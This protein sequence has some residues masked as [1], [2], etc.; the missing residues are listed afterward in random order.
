MTSIFVRSLVGLVSILALASCGGG[1]DIAGDTSDFGVSPEEVKFT[2]NETRTTN[3]D[4]CIGVRGARTVFTIVGGQA[5][6]RIVNSSPQYMDVDK[7]EVSG[8]DPK[9]TVTMN[10]GC[11]DPLTILVLDYHSRSATVEITVEREKEEEAATP[12]L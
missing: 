12:A 11:G 8:K 1:G 3:V 9:F 6:F 10:G 4:S 7:T 2:D 5:P